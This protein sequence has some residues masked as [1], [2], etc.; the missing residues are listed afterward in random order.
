MTVSR[1]HIM[2]PAVAC[3]SNV[4]LSVALRDLLGRAELES[5]EGGSIWKFTWPKTDIARVLGVDSDSM[6][7]S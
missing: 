1:G 6:L 4:R 3:A 7:A 2:A 5:R